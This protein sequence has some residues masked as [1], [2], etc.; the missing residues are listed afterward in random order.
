[1]DVRERGSEFFG[2]VPRRGERFMMEDVWL[3]DMPRPRERFDP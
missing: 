1:M 3:G 2:C